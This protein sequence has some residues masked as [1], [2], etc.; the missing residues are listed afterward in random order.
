MLSFDHGGVNLSIG[1]MSYATTLI[2]WSELSSE[3]G[4]YRRKFPGSEYWLACIR[5]LS[6]LEFIKEVECV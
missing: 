6:H 1:D 5:K 2:A 3:C 4:M